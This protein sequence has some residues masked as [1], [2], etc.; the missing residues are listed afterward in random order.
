M[1]TAVYNEQQLYI[2][3]CLNTVSFPWQ[4]YAGQ[5]QADGS[6]DQVYCMVESEDSNTLPVMCPAP[7]TSPVLRLEGM[8]SQGID[9]MWEMPQQYGDAAV[10]VSIIDCHTFMLFVLCITHPICP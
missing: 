8:H 7:P 10:S 6:S 1:L 3:V 9:I 4:A 5:R 2:H